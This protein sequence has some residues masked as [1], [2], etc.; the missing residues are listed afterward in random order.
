MYTYGVL[1]NRISMN[2]MVALTSTNA[3]KLFG[4]FPQ[5]GTI[6]VG[7]DAD[8][9]VWN[10]NFSTFI[11][12]KNQMQNVDYTPYEGFEQYGRVL[13]AFLRGNKVIYNGKLIEDK[14]IGKYLYR[15][16]R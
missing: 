11:N 3:A 8:I 6:A 1:K 10:P 14:P 16:M 5:K 2:E 12:A 15:K 4:L 7:S 9:V 13:H